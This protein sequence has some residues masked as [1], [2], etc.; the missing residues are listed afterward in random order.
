VL[1]Q[2]QKYMVDLGPRFTGSPALASWHDF[3]ASELAASGLSVAREPI[4]LEWWLHKKWSLK[5]IQNGVETDYPVASYYPYSG[6]TPE[7]G[8]VAA[9]VDAGIGT[10]TDF[11]AAAGKIAF[12]EENMLPA[13]AA[14][15]Y[16]VAT[17]VHDPDLTLSPAT[18]Y[19]R[20]AVS[21]LTPQE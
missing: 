2:W 6:S 7:G 16:G 4:P 15:F 8:I 9:L 5:L 1:A 11:S 3:L 10:P 13:T 20:A 14:I 17:Y 12:Y 18:D 19:K 21:F